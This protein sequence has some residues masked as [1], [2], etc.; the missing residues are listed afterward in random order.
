MTKK[1]HNIEPSHKENLRLNCFISELYHTFKK[2]I[3][4]L[5]YRLLQ[6][7][8]KGNIFQLVLL[9]QHNLTIKQTKKLLKILHERKIMEQFL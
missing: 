6:R 2:K 5:L 3:M 9:G 7:I 8:V 4:H 1:I